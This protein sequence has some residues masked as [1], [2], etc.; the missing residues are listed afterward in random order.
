MIDQIDKALA[1]Q[2]A[3]L[4]EDRKKQATALEMNLR[5]H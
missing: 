1:E 5:L 4:P 2:G 3:N